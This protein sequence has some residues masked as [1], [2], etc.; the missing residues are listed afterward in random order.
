M[1]FRLFDFLEGEISINNIDSDIECFRHE[2]E[3]SVDINEPLNQESPWSIFYFLLYLWNVITINF[4]KWLKSD[5]GLVN[6]LCILGYTLWIP[7]IQLVT[8]NHALYQS[9]P[10]LCNSFLALFPYFFCCWFLYQIGWCLF[11]RFWFAKQ[12]LGAMRGF[13]WGCVVGFDWSWRF[14]LPEWLG[15]KRGLL[16]AKIVGW[17]S[18]CRLADTL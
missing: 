17:V 3:L 6:L 15:F 11:N 14:L 12:F 2:S 18:L 8:Q 5:H 13:C 9:L 1:E 16:R 10:V 7:H 4:V